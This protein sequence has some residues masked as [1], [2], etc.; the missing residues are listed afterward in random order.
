MK[1]LLV[2]FMLFTI[3]NVRANDSSIFDELIAKSVQAMSE[4][5]QIKKNQE[6]LELLRKNAKTAS[7]LQLFKSSD[8]GETGKIAHEA[9][10]R[11]Y[12]ALK[13]YLLSDN[14]EKHELTIKEIMVL[15]HQLLQE[16]KAQAESWSAPTIYTAA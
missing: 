6:Q 15:F 7:D 5:S 16:M 10:T 1:R 11:Y 9:R 13:Q 8:C 14:K 12:E 3:N 4:H 2:L